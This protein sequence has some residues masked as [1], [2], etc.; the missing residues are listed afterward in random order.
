[1]QFQGAE[2]EGGPRAW[3]REEQ[4]ALGEALRSLA[5][6]RLTGS[7]GAA[8]VAAELRRRFEALGYQVAELHFAFSTW[9]GRFG[10]PAVG[11]VY[12]G[13]AGLSAWA[14]VRGRPGTA[15]L[16]LLAAA[17]AVAL[18]GAWLPAAIARL[19]WGRVE[20]A[21]WLVCRPG[22][23]PE[24]LVVAHRDSK[25][26]P[27]STFTRAGGILLAAF[28]W[29]ALAV[30]AVLALI[31]PAWRWAPGPLAA[32]GLA[33]AAGLILGLCRA[34]NGSPGALDNATGL[35]ALLALARREADQDDVAFLVTDGEEL[36]LAGARA[37][38]R[39]LPPARGV[40]NLD[41]LDD[42]GAFHVVE[43]YRWAQR[44]PTSDL[45][46]SLL[47]AAEALGFEARR[48][49]LPPWLL[50]DHVPFARAGLP[51][52]TLMRGTP[53]SL[54]RVHRPEDDAGALTGAGVAAAAA[55][56]ARA[57]D[58]LREKT[59]KG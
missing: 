29:L 53:G 50:V 31:D 37:A 57:L 10:L 9:P 36:G 27:V 19:P 44:G 42:E 48:R 32:A 30:Q 17:A 55:V 51:A 21:N 46:A 39:Q 15:L 45:A 25:S 28:A 23:R 33:A 24:Y 43:G 41:G 5:R 22:A 12:L 1:M 40:I 2:G 35:A 14:L 54:R 52:V 16:A 34:E 20:T 49:S 38:C 59:V 58:G 18:L 13:G 26:Q 56:V 11:V 7:A 3:S 6:P 8:E 47:S 4:R